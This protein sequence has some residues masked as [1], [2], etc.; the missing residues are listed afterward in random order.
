MK[1]SITL[2][3]I[4]ATTIFAACKQD[5]AVTNSRC[6]E[7]PPVGEACL[8]YFERWFYNEGS[9]SCELISYSGCSQKGFETKA[10]CEACV[11]D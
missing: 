10:E 1:L 11:C 4:A 8:A 5:C 7:R 2:L 9:N 6:E 3:T